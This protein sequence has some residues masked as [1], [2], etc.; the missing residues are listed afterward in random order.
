MVNYEHDHY[1]QQNWY[2]RPFHIFDWL[3]TERRGHWFPSSTT[4][5]HQ[6]TPLTNYRQSLISFESS[7][8]AGLFALYQ[9]GARLL[10][11]DWWEIF[12]GVEYKPHPIFPEIEMS[13]NCHLRIGGNQI[14]ETNSVPINRI[15]D[16]GSPIYCRRT[17]SDLLFDI[18]STP[19]A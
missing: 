12:E 1:Y 15:I 6:D 10:R 9:T 17:V 4:L 13:R 19:A 16:E 11:D 3:H 8:D 18:W 7:L 5:F 2:A 14:D